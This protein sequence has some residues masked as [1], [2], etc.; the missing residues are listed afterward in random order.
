MAD[1][2]TEVSILRGGSMDAM[3]CAPSNPRVRLLANWKDVAAQPDL[4]H[5]HSLWTPFS[6]AGARYARRHKIPYVVSAHGM[7]A[8][9]ALK[10]KWLK[11]RLAWWLYQKRDLEGAAM[12]HVTAE[13]EI[14]WLRDLGFKQPCVLA[15][16]GS[17]LPDIDPAKAQRRKEV[18][19]VLFVGRIYP[20]KGLMNLVRAWARVRSAKVPECES[21]KVGG[22]RTCGNTQSATGRGWASANLQEYESAKVSDKD[23]ANSSSSGNFRTSELQNFRT[24]PWQ[25]VIAGP[26]QAGHK[27]ELVAEAKRLGLRVEDKCVNALVRDCVGTL[28]LNHA[29]DDNKAITHSGNHAPLPDI[30]FTGPVYGQDKDALHRVADLFV[31]PSFTENF[32]VVVTDALS[33]GIPVI[34]TKG[35]PWSELL[36]NSD[37]SL[38]HYCK[39]SLVDKSENKRLKTEVGKETTVGNRQSAWAG[40][41]IQPIGQT[42]NQPASQSIA[43]TNELMNERTNELATSGRCGWWIDI[44]VEPLAEALMEAMGLTDEERRVLGANGRRLVEM[45][46]TWPAIASDMKRAYEW[47]LHGGLTPDCVITGKAMR[48]G[49]YGRQG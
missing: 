36:G 24:F 7:L 49:T 27:A 48:G 4:I 31:L 17:D 15:P 14:R 10:H 23:N 1:E 3:T 40:S 33:Y 13:S 42:A 38:V 20:V 16:L 9:W 8:P 22:G 26:D 29:V 35:T 32:G 34:T 11:K 44:G 45:K 37:S 46:Y 30:L 47:A 21:A 12:F 25:L 19:T 43:P 6:H 2:Q 39:S 28:V 5:V 18:K 41:A